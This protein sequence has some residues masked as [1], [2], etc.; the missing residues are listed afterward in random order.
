MLDLRSAGLFG[1]AFKFI[2]VL[3]KWLKES[4]RTQVFEVDKI[5]SI[6]YSIIIFY[7]L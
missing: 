4:H 1:Q 7:L 2:D 3:G 5:V 6:G